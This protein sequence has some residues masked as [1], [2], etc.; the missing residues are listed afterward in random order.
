MAQKIRDLVARYLCGETT[1][2]ETLTSLGS[3][4]GYK[5]A[6]DLLRCAV[7]ADDESYLSLVPAAAE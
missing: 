3:L 1:Y 6:H 7:E 4:V 2:P 5:Q